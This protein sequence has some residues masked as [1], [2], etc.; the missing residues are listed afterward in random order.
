MDLRRI[1]AAKITDPLMPFLSKVGLTP[2][3]LTW[4]GLAI[5][6]AAAVFI[7]IG[8]L[9]AGGL[10]ILFSGLFDILDGA[11][12]RYSNK[13]TRFG[14][15]LDSTFDRLSEGIIFLGLVILYSNGA[16]SVEI[17]LIFVVMI[18]SFLTSYIRARAEGLGMECKTGLF[19]RT[20]RVIVLA[21][22]LVFNQVLLA[23]ILLAVFTVIT[24]IQRLFHVW[25]E[26]KRNK[27]VL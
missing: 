6:V 2:D 13:S 8:N 16:H 24:V 15:L 5:T 3:I 25:Q 11:L 14:A 10:L 26:T 21:I 22:G 23:L 4:I 19:T 7:A 17:L 27:P 18:C 9:L 20:E 1:A 12:A